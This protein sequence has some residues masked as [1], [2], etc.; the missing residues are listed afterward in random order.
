MNQETAKQFLPLVQALADGK[1]LQ[2]HC[3]VNGHD[4]IRDTN[5]IN[6]TLDPSRYRVKPDVVRMALGPEDVPPGSVIRRD[7]LWH[8]VTSISNNGVHHGPEGNVSFTFWNSLFL[9]GWE[10]K[11]PGEDWTP[12]HKERRAE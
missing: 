10:I 9:C 5:N 12:C 11:R 4:Q 6:F 8:L 2:Y 7:G 3:I 1:T